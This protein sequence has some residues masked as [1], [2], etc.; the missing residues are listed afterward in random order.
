MSRQ[1]RWFASLGLSLALFALLGPV[2]LSQ[3]TAPS[4]SKD[5]L[6]DGS[7]TVGPITKAVAEEFRGVRPDVN[8]SVAVSGTGGGFRRFCPGNGHPETDINDASRPIKSSELERCQNDGVEFIELPVA[9]DGLT[10]AVDR[11]TQIWPAGAPVCLTVGE[12]RR[13]WEI[14]SE[15]VITRWN[16]VRPD[17]ADAEIVLSGPAETSGTRDFLLEAL[18]LEAQREDGFF[19]EDDQLLAQQISQEPLGLTYFGFA[20]FINNTDLVQAVA[21]DPRDEVL[22]NSADCNG[23]LPSFESIESFTYKPFSR[24]LFIYVNA[25]SANRDAVD[26]FVDFYVSNNVLPDA[27]FMADVGYVA[28]GQEAVE[29][30]QLC[31]HNRVRGTAFSGPEPG[32]TVTEILKRKNCGR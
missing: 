12:L 32:L 27:D 11:E 16:Q 17:L 20:F 10:M 29:L 6:V 7:S 13:L 23:V 26:D 2:S 5:I 9:L 14:E 4:G 1:I 31:W 24:P 28:L 3:P 8:V 22:T 21:I 30:T 15:G 19:T 18:D 25:Q